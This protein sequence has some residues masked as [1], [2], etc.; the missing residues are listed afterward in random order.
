M[1]AVLKLSRRLGPVQAVFSTMLRSRNVM[2]LPS[3]ASLRELVTL[4]LVRDRTSKYYYYYYFFTPHSHIIRRF[5]TVV[6]L[7]ASLPDSYAPF[8]VPLRSTTRVF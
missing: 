4:F 7:A 2:Q 6:S 1:I 3:L 8:N 5:A